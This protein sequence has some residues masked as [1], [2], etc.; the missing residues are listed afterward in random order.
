MARIIAARSKNP[1]LPLISY[2]YSVYERDSGKSINDSFSEA[3]REMYR[4]KRKRNPVKAVL[5]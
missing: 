1:A 2:G 5:N 4:C 3:D